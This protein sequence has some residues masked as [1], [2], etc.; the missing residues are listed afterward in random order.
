MERPLLLFRRGPSTSPLCRVLPHLIDIS[1]PGDPFISDHPK[2]TGGIDPLDWLP[3]SWSNRGFGMRLPALAKG[4]AGL[5]ETLV[6]ILQSLIHRSR[7]WRY[8]SRRLIKNAVCRTWLW[9]TCRPH[10][11]VTRRGGKAKACRWHTD[12]IWRVKL[13]HPG[14]RQVGVAVGTDASNVRLFR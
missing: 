12:W 1:Q 8:V 4:I 2:V 7:S 5:F 11:E 6:A 3:K 14:R 13:F 9:L 10:R